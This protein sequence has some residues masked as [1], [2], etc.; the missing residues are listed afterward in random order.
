LLLNDS[1]SARTAFADTACKCKEETS[2]AFTD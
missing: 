2:T 1:H